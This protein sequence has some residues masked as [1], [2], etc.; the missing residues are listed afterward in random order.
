MLAYEPGTTYVHRLDP[1]AKLFVQVAFATAVITR[2]TPTDV[3]VLTVLA[4]GILGAAR[5]SPV[6]GVFAFRFVILLLAAAVLVETLT[7]NPPHLVVSAA[8][9]PALAGYRVVLV[10]LVSAAYIQTTPIRDSQTAIQWA[11]PGK[12]GRALA[13]GVSFVFR[14]FPLVRDDLTRARHAVAAR[15]GGERTTADQARIMGT[16]GVARTIDRSDRLA[17]ALRARCLSWNPTPAPLRFT[18]YDLPAIGFAVAVL[19]WGF[20]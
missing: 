4:L 18:R 20:L 13:I 7:L 2:T 15:L 16:T 17:L 1:R 5:V 3:A 6:R 14:F 19:V 10:L 12:P 11:I 9:D 8:R